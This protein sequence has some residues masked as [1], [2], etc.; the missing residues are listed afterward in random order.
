MLPPRFRSFIPRRLPPLFVIGSYYARPARRASGA[1]F[2]LLA[3]SLMLSL[4][5]LRYSIALAMPLYWIFIRYILY[6][7]F[8]GFSS[9]LHAR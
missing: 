4:M 5:R 7:L 3:I 6:T 9:M 8:A 1:A 2:S